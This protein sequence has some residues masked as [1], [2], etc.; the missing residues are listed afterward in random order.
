[1][2]KST[3]LLALALTALTLGAC[4]VTDGAGV[5]NEELAKVVWH[6]EHTDTSALKLRAAHY[7]IDNMQWHH[8]RVEDRLI[9]DA[10]L[11]DSAF[12]V[13]HIDYA[14]SIW[15]TSPFARSL[16]FEEFEE[17]ILPYRAVEGYGCN[18]TARDRRNWLAEHIGLP[19]TITTL[20]G[21]IQYYN[22]N[23]RSL[24]IQ[25][26]K[27]ASR[28]RSGMDDLLHEDFTDCSDKATQCCLNLRALGIP[29][30]VEHNL[31]YRTFK[32]HHYH[33]AVWDA[34][35]QRWIKFDAE[36]IKDYP[37]EGDW[38]SAELLNLYRDT[39][40]PQPDAPY[41]AERF[42]PRG[43]TSPCIK[44]VT[45]H[46]LPVSVA[47]ASAP[48]DLTPYLA[49]FHRE[50][51]GL[52]AF[53]PG[54]FVDGQAVFDHA[55]PTVWYVVVTYSA[56]G[57]PTLLTRPFYLEEPTPGK[58]AIRSAQ[59]AAATA[60]KMRVDLTRKYPVKEKLR[61][62]AATL[63]GT[64]IEGANRPDFADAVTLWRLDSVPAPKMVRYDF[65]RTGAFRYYR[66]RTPGACEVSVLQWLGAEGPI[67]VDDATNKAYDGK[68]TTAPTDSTQIALSLPRPTL[69][70][71]VN[72]VPINADNAVT[73]GHRYELYTWTDDGWQQIGVATAQSERLT[74]D[75]VPEGSLLWLKD[76]TA[77][78]EE[79]PFFYR[80]NHQEFIY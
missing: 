61:Q 15:H 9:D 62:R 65:G 10:E 52:Q 30:V 48:Q 58:A 63:R 45:D 34:A 1:M 69:I 22:R 21:W 8:S 41:S 38:T 17:L 66:L 37:G 33:C 31:G 39:Y 67:D 49:T 73:P 40:A 20:E 42:M 11:L 16:S 36:G 29:C 68:M 75:N 56:D 54:R 71:G 2:R 13:E 47:V 43:F 74:F 4:S 50:S 5:M 59:F 23:I 64:T 55:V 28:W 25:G 6:Y 57:R 70:T 24:R 78:Q 51:G 77:G 32:A 18:V 26:G 76:T 60:R 80:N 3:K 72:L 12:L 46:T 27:T 35:R 14:F 53:T 79:M 44:D 19:D 7:L